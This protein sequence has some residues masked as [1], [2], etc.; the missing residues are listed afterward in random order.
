M[1]PTLTTI[2]ISF[3]VLTP[4]LGG[5]ALYLLRK[6]SIGLKERLITVST[7]IPLIITAFLYGPLRRG[8]ELQ[9]T[10]DLLPPLGLS[11]RVDILGFYMLLLFV[12]FGFVVSIYAQQ[13]MKGDKKADRF[14]AC[15]LLALGG[16]YG[17]ALAGDFFT[18]YLFFEFMS[19]MFFVLV[20]H[21]QTE[22]SLKAG[23]KFLF[24]TITA[25]VALFLSAVI[26]LRETGS[27]ALGQGGLVTEASP[28]ALLAFCGFMVAFGTKAALVPLHFWMP[29][30]YARAPL[31]AAV[32]SSAIMLKTGAYGMLR[33]FGDVYGFSFLAGAG[34][35]QPLIYLASLSILL[36]SAIALVQDDLIRRLAYSGIAQVGYII[37]GISL[38]QEAAVA[39]AVYHIMAHAFMKGTLFLCA[40]A[41]IRGMGTRK[42]SEMK[43]AGHQMPGVMLC[44][45]A[46]ALTAVGMPP[47]NVF[48]SKWYLSLGALEEGMPVLVGVLLVSSFLNAAYYL[49]IAIQAFFGVPAGHGDGQEE[50]EAFRQTAAAR[51]EGQGDFKAGSWKTAL[52]ILILTI[53]CGAFGLLAV[54]WPLEIVK[55]GVK[56]FF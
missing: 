10:F 27:L 34:W 31:P 24:M 53:G 56:A 25:G 52:P 6:S 33:V 20:I 23:L 41:V 55:A 42:I 3:I 16:C 18:F 50:E 9:K 21:H 51:G 35:A 29:D 44:F 8:E 30:A 38:L 37:L 5:G 32:I 26:I 2:L 49:P 43:G 46:A 45:S 13:Y 39:G 47:F 40:G 1:H 36:G 4:L 19:L 17:V 28:L 7:L 54:N 15:M 48:I 14:F 12:F 11:Y 22:A